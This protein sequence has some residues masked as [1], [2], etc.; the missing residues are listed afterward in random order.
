VRIL[1]RWLSAVMGCP[2]CSSALPPRAITIR[3]VTVL[4]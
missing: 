3:M 2:R 1:A 4:S